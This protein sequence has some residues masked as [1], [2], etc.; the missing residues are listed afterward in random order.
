MHETHYKTLEM[1]LKRLYFSKFPGEHAAGPLDVL[2]PL[3]ARFREIHV[4]SPK[5]SKSVPSC[6]FFGWRSERLSRRLILKSRFLRIFCDRKT[7]LKQFTVNFVSRTTFLRYY[8]QGRRKI[9]NWGGG[10]IFI[11]SC[12]QT[13][14]TIDFKI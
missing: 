12:S 8:H 2:A 3:A 13:G 6:F 11:Y 14:K 1:V 9:D 5:I 7:N 10:P 4:Y